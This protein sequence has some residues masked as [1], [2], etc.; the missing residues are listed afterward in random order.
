MRRTL[1]LMLAVAAAGCIDELQPDP[2]GVMSLAV[3]DLGFQQTGV[4]F[5]FAVTGAP[6]NWP[7]I[8]VLATNLETPFVSAAET[9][10]TNDSGQHVVGA[11]VFPLHRDAEGA[12][13]FPAG[14]RTVLVGTDAQ[15][16]DYAYF[17]VA[18]ATWLTTSSGD[19]W[20][21]ATAETGTTLN[22]DCRQRA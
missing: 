6:C 21:E 19:G 20:A 4:S 5:A 10:L 9:A 7:G 2:H 11:A 16:G 17:V 15:V 3:R 18:N 22:V 13:A 1:I 12:F 8:M 14:T